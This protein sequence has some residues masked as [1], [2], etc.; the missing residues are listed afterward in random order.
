[1]NKV[2]T[3]ARLA[4]N[5]RASPGI[6]IGI[7][8]HKTLT[9]PSHTLNSTVYIGNRPIFNMSKLV[10]LAVALCSASVMSQA[11]KP[12]KLFGNEEYRDGGEDFQ[13]NGQCQKLT[14]WL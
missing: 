6:N 11:P 10:L 13:V 5:H 3:G 9:T 4:I 2:H 1:M 12:V 8:N 7:L 14:G